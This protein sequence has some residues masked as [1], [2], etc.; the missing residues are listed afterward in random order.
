MGQPASRTGR[1]SFFIVPV[2][3]DTS[4]TPSAKANGS[5]GDGYEIGGIQP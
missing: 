1:I 2:L 4:S 5:G 3:I